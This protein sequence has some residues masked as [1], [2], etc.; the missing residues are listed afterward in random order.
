MYPTREP[1][2]HAAAHPSQN[3]PVMGCLQSN[4][5]EPLLWPVTATHAT[6]GP[7]SQRFLLW[8]LR[9]SRSPF[10]ETPQTEAPDDSGERGDGSS[11]LGIPVPASTTPSQRVL[12]EAPCAHLTNK[13]PSQPGSASESPG[14]SLKA[15][16][17]AHP[18]SESRSL[19]VRSGPCVC[20]EPE[21][22]H[23]GDSTPRN[24]RQRSS[25]STLCSPWGALTL[26]LHVKWLCL[27]THSAPSSLLSPAPQ[28]T[29][30]GGCRPP[31]FGSR[32]RLP[33]WR[34]A[35]LRAFLLSL[36]VPPW[37]LGSSDAPAQTLWVPRAAR[38]WERSETLSMQPT[39]GGRAAPMRP[40]APCSCRDTYTRRP[41]PLAE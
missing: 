31:G 21:S 39:P 1:P 25:V 19:R 8:L 10:R 16:S 13:G 26:P 12:T 6:M 18:T 23:R 33:G 15:R 35:F 2:S 7:R 29:V 17:W 41:L 24:S 37:P 32:Q 4:R 11:D 22:S 5:R 9:A 40:G 38:Q 14:G 20:N 36:L 27:R 28:R 3:P 30:N 34:T